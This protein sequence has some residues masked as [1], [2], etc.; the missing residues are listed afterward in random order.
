MS[1]EFY[2]LI[3]IIDKFLQNMFHIFNKNVFWVNESIGID[4]FFLKYMPSI[5][6][7]VN[8]CIKSLFF[9]KCCNIEQFFNKVIFAFR[10]FSHLFHRFPPISLGLLL[11]S[12]FERFILVCH[13]YIGMLWDNVAILS[14]ASI[15]K[16]RSSQQSKKTLW[17]TPF[18]MVFNTEYSSVFLIPRRKEGAWP[19]LMIDYDRRSL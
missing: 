10:L 3:S 7:F 13:I 14:E 18:G 1:S 4:T 6:T 19:E 9:I 17:R 16:T 5:C 2:P 8:E 15:T 12:N 11:C